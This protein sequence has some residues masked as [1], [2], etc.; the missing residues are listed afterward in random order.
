MNRNEGFSFHLVLRILAILLFFLAGLGGGW[1]TPTV[2]PW[3][4]RLVS[5]GLFC[6][7]LS[8]VISV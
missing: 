4:G 6:W 1:A 5:W 7:C 8:E 3:N 2:W